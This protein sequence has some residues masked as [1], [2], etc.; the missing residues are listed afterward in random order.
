MFRIQCSYALFLV[1]LKIV[2]NANTWTK[3]FELYIYLIENSNS[4]TAINTEK[5]IFIGVID[6]VVYSKFTVYFYSTYF[7]YPISKVSFFHAAPKTKPT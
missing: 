3:E 6:E 1:T 5:K 2:L 4:Y 7:I